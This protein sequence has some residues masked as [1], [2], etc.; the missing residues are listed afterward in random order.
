M[1][2]A[3]YRRHNGSIVKYELRE[4]K[5]RFF[6]RFGLFDHDFGAEVESPEARG[7]SF[8][9]YEMERE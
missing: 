8:I 1:T 3:I 2:Y 5:D 4:I 9:K 7:E 6:T